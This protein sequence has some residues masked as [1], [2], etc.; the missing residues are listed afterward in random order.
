M[1][2]WNVTSTG[3]VPLVTAPLMVGSTQTLSMTL[4]PGT[5]FYGMDQPLSYVYDP[6]GESGPST[7]SDSGEMLA[8]WGVLIVPSG[9][10]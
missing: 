6:Y 2:I 4:A 7:G 1:G 9:G 3:W 5:Y 8:L 10:T